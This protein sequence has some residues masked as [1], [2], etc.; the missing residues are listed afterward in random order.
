VHALVPGEEGLEL[1]V[2]EGGIDEA[3]DF[4]IAAL[5]HDAAVG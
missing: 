4:D 1:I 5:Q 3:E 2:V